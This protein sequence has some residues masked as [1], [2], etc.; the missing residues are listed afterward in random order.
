MKG[1]FKLSLVE[2]KLFTREFFAAFFT[3]VFPVMLLVFFGM[4]YGNE[5]TDFFKGAGFVDIAVP[6][7]TAMII[8][9]SG[10]I[11]ITTI[12]ASYREKG[13]LRR[14]HAT[15]LRP[16]TIL[17]A[18]VFVIFIM[19]TLGM[20]L[21][22]I[23][24][25]LIYNMQFEGNLFSVTAGFTLSSMS[26]FSMGFLIAGL[27]PTARTAQ[28]TAMVLFY[29]MIFLSGATIPLEVL[30]ENI[31]NFATI[32]PLKHVVIL[33]RGLWFG[34]NW[35]QYLLEVSVLTGILLIAIPISAKTFR[36]E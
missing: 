21:L 22:I 33:L 28:A 7:Y 15:P 14:L 18:H 24:G 30:P 32:L 20:V 29:P 26:F 1:L 16:Q 5:K 8:A 3:L 2:F 36:W 35:G 9:S 12:I 31:Q 23:A 6:S 17:S 4:I 25:K 34:N 13:I 27:I 10:L 19:T 11:S